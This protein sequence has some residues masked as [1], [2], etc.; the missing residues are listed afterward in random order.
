VAQLAVA[1][2]LANPAVDV[3][4]VGARSADQIR[5]TTPGADLRLTGEDLVQ[6]ELMLRGEVAVGGPAPEA[7]PRS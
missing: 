2:T 1:W 4:I 6:I 7:M 3:T 5:Q